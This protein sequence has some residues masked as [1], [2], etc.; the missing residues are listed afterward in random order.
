[1]HQPHDDK[2]CP[3]TEDLLSGPQIEPLALSGNKDVADLIDN[4]YANSGF[5]ARRLADAAA[6]NGSR[7]TRRLA[8]RPAAGKP[9]AES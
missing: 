4:V 6:G 2:P 5:N 3:A 1:M 8:G 9:V 7:G